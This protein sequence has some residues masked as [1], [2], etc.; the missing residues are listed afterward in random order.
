MSSIPW[1]KEKVLITGHTGFKGAWLA[2]WLLGRGAEL[3]GIALPPETS[4]N[5]FEQLH[6][7][8]RMH[9]HYADIRD[10]DAVACIIADFSPDVVFHLAA[11]P[12]VRQSY[13][14]P[15]ETFSTNVLGT[16]HI[17]DAMRGAAKPCAGIFVATDKVYENREWE[18]AYRETDAL[19]GADPYSAS[20]ACSE[21]AVSAYRAAFFSRDCLPGIVVSTVRAGNVI[22]G[23]DWAEHR[24]VPDCM[25]ALLAGRPIDVRNRFSVRPWQ[26][27]L[28]PLHGYLLLG[29]MLLQ[30]SRANGSRAQEQNTHSVNFGP[31]VDRDQTVEELVTEILKFWPGEWQRID[32]LAPPHEAKTLR[33]ATERARD[34]IDWS[35]IWDFQETVSRTVDWYRAVFEK[36]QDAGEQTRQQI[37]E[38]EAAC[39]VRPN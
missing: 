34:V 17:L 4:P 9:H 7:E 22:G 26:H 23:G 39:A 13:V 30:I 8:E 25:R 18:F 37:A 21:L 27:V 35:P 28:D 38:F 12:L 36:G 14:T 32:E 2:E 1:S 5:L 10:R 33:L 29:Q 31:G 20:K 6:L 24:I 15:V 3:A 16:V 19:G 11:Q